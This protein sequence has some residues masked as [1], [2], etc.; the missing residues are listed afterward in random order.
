MPDEG[1]AVPAG[2]NRI[3]ADCFVLRIALETT[4]WSLSLDARPG[5]ERRLKHLVALLDD[6]ARRTAVRI[7]VLGGWPASGLDELVEL[8]SCR[9]PV[10]GQIPD[11]NALAIAAMEVVRDFHTLGRI[12]REEGDEATAHLLYGRVGRIEEAA[13]RLGGFDA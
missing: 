12:A 5:V 10:S 4:V 3:L 13:R 6:T 1:A 2:L 7:R 11:P 9:P 8:A